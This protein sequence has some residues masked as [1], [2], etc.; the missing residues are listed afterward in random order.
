MS[1][2]RAGQD[3]MAVAQSGD[4]ATLIAEI[5]SAMCSELDTGN[6]VVSI[7][8]GTHRRL[9]EKHLTMQ[10]INVI[11]VLA[12]GQYVSLNALD[13]LST[14]IV[15]G[16]PDVSRFAQQVG[17]LVDRTAARFRRVLIFGELVPLMHADGK[18]A[19]AAELDKLWRSFIASR[20]V[21]REF[22]CPDDVIHSSGSSSFARQA[23]GP[24]IPRGWS[25]VRADTN[26]GT[27]LR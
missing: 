20:P 26:V 6:A 24:T 15:D 5:G 11:A 17:A 1:T 2:R 18:H 19:G 14:I 27:A 12:K 22:E 21:F 25:V 23:F 8:S 7:V 4:D 9:L 13:A 3:A 16:L 10:G